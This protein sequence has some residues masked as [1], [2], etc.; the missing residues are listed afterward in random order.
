MSCQTHPHIK[1]S[2]YPFHVHIQFR[3]QGYQGIAIIPEEK[4]WKYN[5]FVLSYSKSYYNKFFLLF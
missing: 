5:K 3:C 2:I 4:V 1:S